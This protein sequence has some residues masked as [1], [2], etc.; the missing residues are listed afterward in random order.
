MNISQIEIGTQANIIDPNSPVIKHNMLDIF[1]RMS[2]SEKLKAK[3]VKVRLAKTEDEKNK[4][5]KDLLGIIV[6]SNTTTRKKVDGD[7][8]TGFYVG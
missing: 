5:K 7:V 8:H 1:T 3:T 4:F 2:T 6:S